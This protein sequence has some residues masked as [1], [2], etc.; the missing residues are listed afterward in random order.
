M[1]NGYN[2]VTWLDKEKRN[3]IYILNKEILKYI[4]HLWKIYSYVKE[5][6]NNFDF[7]IREDI[8]QINAFVPRINKISFQNIFYISCVVRYRYKIYEV[9]RMY[10]YM[11]YFM[12]N[13]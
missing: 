2:R 5:M 12:H 7:D 1:T 9:S 4:N 3:I 10:V 11:I 13:Q 6:T 8:W